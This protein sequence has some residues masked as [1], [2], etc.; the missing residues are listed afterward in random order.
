MWSARR[1][2]DSSCSTNTTVLPRS[3]S[4]DSTFNSIEASDLPW[5]LEARLLDPLYAKAELYQAYTK[6][7]TWASH[8]FLGLALAVAPVGGWVAVTG[9]LAGLRATRNRSRRHWRRYT[10]G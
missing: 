1:K 7:F 8:F 6:R 4:A 3:T 10:K 5:G 2:T 9:R